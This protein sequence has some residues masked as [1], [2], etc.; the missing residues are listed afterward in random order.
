MPLV[1]HLVLALA[2]E[3]VKDKR[4]LC[5]ERASLKPF[6]VVEL[7]PN[8]RSDIIATLLAITLKARVSSTSAI[9]RSVNGPQHIGRE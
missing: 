2:G 5:N 4:K 3:I 6:V 8:E 7:F 1:H 9:I